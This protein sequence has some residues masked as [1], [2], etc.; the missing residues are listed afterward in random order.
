MEN[1]QFAASVLPQIRHQ[2]NSVGEELLTYLIDMAYL[3]ALERARSI[4]RDNN[5]TEFSSSQRIRPD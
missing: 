3:E 1:L 2:A 4:Q 5:E